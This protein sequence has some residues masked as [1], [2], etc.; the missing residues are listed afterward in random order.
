MVDSQETKGSPFKSG[1]QIL[2]QG[3][4]FETVG[5]DKERVL[6]T[7][8]DRD[9]EGFLSLYRLYM[10]SNDPTEWT[11]ANKYLENW[12]HWERLTE[13]SWFKSYIERWRRELTLKLKS[14]ALSRVIRE[15][16]TNSKESFMANKYLLDKGWEDKASKEPNT[17]GRPSK[18]EVKK[19]AKE[20][21]LNE[22][23]LTKDFQRI[24]LVSN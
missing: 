1:A 5:A 24:S 8:K 19:A 4:F 7:L 15:S 16:K 21:A 9:H 3:L 18:D 2:L 17:R 14:E 11:F 22:D 10:E 13:C 6:Y 12:A 23:R 20:I